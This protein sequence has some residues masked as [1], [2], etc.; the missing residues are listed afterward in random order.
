MPSFLSHTRAATRARRAAHARRA[1][2]TALATPAAQVAH[3]ESLT[4]ARVGHVYVCVCMSV[5]LCDAFRHGMVHAWFL[6]D[7]FQGPYPADA[8][9]HG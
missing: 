8:R 2:H 9:T 4:G 7:V 1:T 5:V 3:L 6:A